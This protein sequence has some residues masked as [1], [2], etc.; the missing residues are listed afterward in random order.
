LIRKRLEVNFLIVFLFTIGMA[1][2]LDAGLVCGPNGRIILKLLG[3][4]ID[5]GG[6]VYL[7]VIVSF[8]Y[9]C[10]YVVHVCVRLWMFVCRACMHARACASACA[11]PGQHSGNVTN[12]PLAMTRP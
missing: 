10:V 5:S 11:G 9:V 4:L 7:H 12:L 1:F 6:I 8:D 2:G 3:T